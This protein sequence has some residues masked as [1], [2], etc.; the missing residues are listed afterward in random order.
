MP[1][2]GKRLNIVRAKVEDVDRLLPLFE[3]YRRFYRCPPAR[4]RA[5]RYMTDRL[6]R[7]ESVVFLAEASGALLGFTQLYPTFASLPMRPWWVLYDLYV[8]PS[9]RRTGVASRLL[10]RARQLAEETDAEGLS[11]ETAHDN[12]AQKL[13][14]AQGWKRDQRFL[15]YELQVSRRR[16]PPVRRASGRGRPKILA[17]S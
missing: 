1:E 16:S 5:R 14:E 7:Q 15:H 13:Y 11:L 3:A 9:A 4:R 8:V 12:P 2:L 10:A 17:R 6:T